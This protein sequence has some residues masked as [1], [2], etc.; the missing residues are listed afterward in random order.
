MSETIILTQ[1][2]LDILNEDG[3]VVVKDSRN[4]VFVIEVDEDE[5]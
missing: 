3:Y 2:E 5:Q 4:R 1:D